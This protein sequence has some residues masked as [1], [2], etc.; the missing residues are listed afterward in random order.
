MSKKRFTD[1]KIWED[2]WFFELSAEYKLFWF[3]LKDNCDHA[4]LW[5]PG[6][7]AFA[8]VSDT[9]VDLDKALEYFNMDKERVVVVDNGRWFLVDFFSFQYGS[10]LNIKNKV[11]ESVF[12]EYIKNKVGLSLLRGVDSIVINGKDYSV[13]EFEVKFEVNVGVK[14]EVNVE[15]KHG[16]IDID[17]DKE[18]EEDID[19]D[20]LS[21]LEEYDS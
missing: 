11:H 19:E 10:R 14:G 12:R 17:K 8:A 6:K 7:R 4:G 9:D 16:L 5:R 13:S 20:I 2:D 1:I 15:V 21:Y 18:K 3:Y